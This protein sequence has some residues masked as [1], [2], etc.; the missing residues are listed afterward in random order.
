VRSAEVT[1]HS[2]GGIATQKHESAKFC[3]F[4]SRIWVTRTSNPHRGQRRG[5]VRITPQRTLKTDFGTQN[6]PRDGVETSVAKHCGDPLKL[7]C[8]KQSK[9]VHS[10]SDLNTLRKVAMWNPVSVF[11]EPSRRRRKNT[12]EQKRWWRGRQARNT[13]RCPWL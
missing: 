7:V 12:G 3:V 13:I 10:Y 5:N 1:I 4:I 9:C 11:V 6:S 2:T 8:S